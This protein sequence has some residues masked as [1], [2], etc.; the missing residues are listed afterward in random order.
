MTLK[1]VDIM[2]EKCIVN[3][4]ARPSFKGLYGFF[5]AICLFLNEVIIHDLPSDIV[6]KDGDI[7][8]LDIGTK[9]DGCYGDAAI[10][11]P[12]GKI[13]K[14]DDALIVCAKD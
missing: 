11:M 8:G 12:I 10:S 1:E 6:L 9:V 2:A 3:L 4:G 7:L 5:G 14:E 13:S